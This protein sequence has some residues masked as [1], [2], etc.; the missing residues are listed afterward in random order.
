MSCSKSFA[1]LS[2]RWTNPADSDRRCDH[3]RDNDH[4]DSVRRIEPLPAP[5]SKELSQRQRKL[6]ISGCIGWSFSSPHQSPVD[7][8]SACLP[9]HASLVLGI[10]P[11]KRFVGLADGNLC[12]L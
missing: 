9:V 4:R 7:D 5:A 11:S 10:L 12:A 1:N 8:N 6:K 2:S 3:S